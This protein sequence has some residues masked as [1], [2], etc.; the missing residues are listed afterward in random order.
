MKKSKQG[1]SRTHSGNTQ[2]YLKNIY[3]KL[4]LEVRYFGTNAFEMHVVFFACLFVF[5]IDIV[6]DTDTK[7]DR[8]EES[9]E[10]LV[11][12]S[13]SWNSLAKA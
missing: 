5:I 9:S 10:L 6:S 8:E 12:S 3:E 7:A 2:E 11:Y 1:T 13:N 4:E